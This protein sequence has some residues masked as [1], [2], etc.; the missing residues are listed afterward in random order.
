MERS[1]GASASR[2]ADPGRRVPAHVGADRIGLLTHV[3]HW[4]YGTLWGGAYGLVQGTIRTRS[5]P[6]GLSFGTGVWGSSYIVLPAMK[7]YKP[8]WEYPRKTLAIDLSYHLVYGL[9]VAGAYRTLE[10][11]RG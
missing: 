11:K 6:A 1:A 9:A 8:I 10:A 4:S 3:V 7:L 5:V 2:Q